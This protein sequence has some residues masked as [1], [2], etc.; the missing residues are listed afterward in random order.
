MKLF[1]VIERDSQSLIAVFSTKRRAL[2][3]LKRKGKRYMPCNTAVYTLDADPL[4]IP[5]LSVVFTAYLKD[6]KK[7]LNNALITNR[8]IK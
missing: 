6:V 2:G 5:D 8:R 7:T 3:F 1:A 4:N